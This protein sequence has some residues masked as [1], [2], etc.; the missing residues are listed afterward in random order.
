MRA[1]AR[2]QFAHPVSPQGAATLTQEKF[3]LPRSAD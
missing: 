2:R 1:G 3:S